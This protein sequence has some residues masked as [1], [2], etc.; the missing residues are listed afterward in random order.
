MASRDPSIRAR[1]GVESRMSGGQARSLGDDGERGRLRKAARPVFRGPRLHLRPPARAL[2]AATRK[3]SSGCSPG[4]SR[5]SGGGP[6]AGCRAALATSP[7]PTTWSRTPCS[8]R[9]GHWV[10]LRAAA[11]RRAAGVSAAGGAEPAARRATARRGR[12]PD[13]TGL[14]ELESR[15]RRIASRAGDRT[16]G[17]RDATSARSRDCAPEE[18][19]AII[20]RVEL[21]M[22]YADLAEALGK[23]SSEAARKTAARAFRRLAEE[24]KVDRGS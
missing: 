16:P 2:G 4:I 13:Q 23:P 5:P 1:S 15:G 14:D 6:A 11:G 8:G 20:G 7:T 19:E 9:L 21:G 10:E 3:R 22:T 24:M 17:G 18:R 12:C